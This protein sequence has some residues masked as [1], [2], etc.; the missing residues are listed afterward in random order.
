MGTQLGAQGAV[1]LASLCDW[2]FCLWDSL[3]DEDIESRETGQTL[4]GAAGPWLGGV[5]A[6]AGVV[7]ERPGH[8]DRERQMGSQILGVGK[9]CARSFAPSGGSG[10]AMAQEV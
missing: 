1:D 9:L 2:C 8:Q 10:G 5:A 6:P 3:G 7:A 4:K